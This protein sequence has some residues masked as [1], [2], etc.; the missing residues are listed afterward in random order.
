V[1]G[2]NTINCIMNTY[3]HHISLPLLSKQKQD[4]LHG[5]SPTLC[6]LYSFC[7]DKRRSEEAY[8]DP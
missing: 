8:D 2:T 5:I 7:D 1:E 6:V 3:R 4:G